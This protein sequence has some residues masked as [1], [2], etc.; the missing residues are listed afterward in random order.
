M[1]EAISKALLSME[2]TSV[3]ETAKFICMIDNIFDALNVTDVNCG[4]KERKILQS[5]YRKVDDFRI[6]V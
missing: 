1:S 2:D 5:P 3:E 4:K 6:E